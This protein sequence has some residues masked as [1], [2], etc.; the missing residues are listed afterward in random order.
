MST[1]SQTQLD[2]R[3]GMANLAAA[4]NIVTTDGPH[5]RL[6]ITVSA[7]CSV[8][9]DPP[10]VLVCVNRRSAARDIFANN[11]VIGVNVLS[12][13][14]HE[15]ARHFSGAT[16]VP[17]EERFGWDIWEHDGDAPTLR[18]A[19]VAAT[20]HVVNIVER[21]THS[22]F[23]VEIDRLRV[24]ETVDALVYDNRSFHRVGQLTAV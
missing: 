4:V 12:S 23:F 22:I 9:D 8:T 15:L 18:Q 1:L 11:G 17:M 16:G 3:N 21:G 2:F 13:E 5:G 7:V 6:G 14:Q 20:G 10:T 19:R 24:R